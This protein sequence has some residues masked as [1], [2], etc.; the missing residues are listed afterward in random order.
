MDATSSLI[1]Q[2]SR[3]EG[4]KNSIIPVFGDALD[5]IGFKVTEKA[6]RSAQARLSKN[7]K[8]LNRWEKKDESLF[9]KKRYEVKL[10]LERLTKEKIECQRQHQRRIADMKFMKPS[11]AADSKKPIQAD[12]MSCASSAS[13][14]I[15]SAAQ[16]T[17]ENVY[18]DAQAVAIENKLDPPKRS[19]L[20]QSRSQTAE[21]SKR[22]KVRRNLTFAQSQQAFDRPLTSVSAEPKPEYL[23]KNSNPEEYHQIEESGNVKSRNDSEWVRK[24]SRELSRSS[25]RH[26]QQ[27]NWHKGFGRPVFCLYHKNNLLPPTVEEKLQKEHWRVKGLNERVERFLA[28]ENPGG[29]L[30]EQPCR[31]YKPKLY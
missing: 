30:A 5:K 22:L 10:Q 15:D 29:S 13:D 17:T 2:E 26:P 21:M 7:I 11:K 25:P 19:R 8:I 27:Q 23:S 3:I 18:P 24:K 31:K 6:N 4:L 9:R 14:V 1:D 20:K 28:K 16:H 12:Q